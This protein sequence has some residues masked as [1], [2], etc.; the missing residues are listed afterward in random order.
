MY[1]IIGVDGNEYGPVSADQLRQWI[2]EK[3][4][5]A[6]T[7]ARPE[8][9]TDWQA[10]GTLPEFADMF[11]STTVGNPPVV[12]ATPPAVAPAP[13]GSVPNYLVQSIL[14]TLCC[15]LPLG[16]PAIIFAAQVNGKLKN[17]DVAGA[18]AS[19]AKAKM[20]C[21]IAF[22]CGIVANI[23]VGIIQFFFVRKSMTHGG[24]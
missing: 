16:I 6:Q 10:L 14:V 1:K 12:A 24:F 18:Q 11:P 5:N 15:C 2:T 7:Q 23:I 4:I 17:G 19:S 8:P 22:G 20:W 13:A 3:R 21:W 9:G